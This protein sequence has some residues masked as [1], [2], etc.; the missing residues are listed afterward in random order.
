MQETLSI[1]ISDVQDTEQCSIICLPD[2]TF[3]NLK[4]WCSQ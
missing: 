4:D 2:A 3:P 1:I